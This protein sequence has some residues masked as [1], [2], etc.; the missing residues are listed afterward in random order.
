MASKKQHVESYSSIEAEYIDN[1]TLFTCHVVVDLG[2]FH[3]QPSNVMCDNI[4][5]T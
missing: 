5:P 4:S 1:E 3:T 2:L